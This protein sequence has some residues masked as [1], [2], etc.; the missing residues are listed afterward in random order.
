MSEVSKVP[1]M[2]KIKREC[3]NC[4]EK[5]FSDDQNKSPEHLV[6]DS[7]VETLHN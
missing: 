3:L 6:V 5:Q 7:R 2:P 1:K 4:L